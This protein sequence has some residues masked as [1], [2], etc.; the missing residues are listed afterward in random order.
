[1]Y[2]TPWNDHMLDMH[3]Y[4][5]SSMPAVQLTNAAYQAA[6]EISH[7]ACLKVAVCCCRIVVLL[8]HAYMPCRWAVIDLCRYN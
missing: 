8:S 5:M 1:M 4:Q 6:A 2:Y 7:T 3:Q